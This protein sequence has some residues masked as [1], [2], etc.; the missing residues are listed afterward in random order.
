MEVL[1][2]LDNEARQSAADAQLVFRRTPTPG[3]HPAFVSGLAD[4]VEERLNGTPKADRPACTG[5]GPWYDVCRAG[6]CENTRLGFRPA[7]AGLQP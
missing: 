5:I 4:L 6:C 1:W 3:V 7:T 2:D